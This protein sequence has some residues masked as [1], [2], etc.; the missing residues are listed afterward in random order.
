MVALRPCSFSCEVPSEEESPQEKELEQSLQHFLLW[1]ESRSDHLA[2]LVG[3]MALYLH[4]F[5]TGLFY[6]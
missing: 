1:E 2:L 6:N 3:Q 4:S 5:S